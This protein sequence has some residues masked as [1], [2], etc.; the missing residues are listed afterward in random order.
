[1][2]KEG[3]YAVY[4]ITLYGFVREIKETDHTIQS[5]I[6]AIKGL[7]S[8]SDLKQNHTEPRK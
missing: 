7:T 8:F 2:L 3:I 6:P 5:L 1:V 4:L